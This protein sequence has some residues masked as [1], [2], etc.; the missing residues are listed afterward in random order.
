MRRWTLWTMLPLVLLAACQS[1]QSGSPAVNESRP[2][3]QR[4]ADAG[5]CKTSSISSFPELVNVN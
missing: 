3:P 1:G 2:C 5:Q 4:Q